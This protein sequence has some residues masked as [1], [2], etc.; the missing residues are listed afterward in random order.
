MA[1]TIDTAFLI[2]LGKGSR[3]V[4]ADSLSVHFKG[5]SL[6][7]PTPGCNCELYHVPKKQQLGRYSIG[8]HFAR[9][10]GQEHNRSV[11]NFPNVEDRNDEGS[12]ADS[13]WASFFDTNGRPPVGA[14]IIYLNSGNEREDFQ[15]RRVFRRETNRFADGGYRTYK[16]TS[17]DRTL[18]IGNAADLRRMGTH[19]D[20]ANPFYN[21]VMIS[22][23]GYKVPFR[24]FFNRNY[25]NLYEIAKDRGERSIH[26]PIATEVEPFTH[27]LTGGRGK[28]PFKVPCKTQE[29]VLNGD[30]QVRFIPVLLSY[31]PDVLQSLEDN[32]RR[33]VWP[34]ETWV[35]LDEVHRRFSLVDK[36]RAH[37]AVI[38]IYLKVDDPDQFA[39]T[40]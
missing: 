30:T 29:A 28:T 22:A 25:Q 14:R 5:A 7:C 4:R 15:L 17:Y 24:Q 13:R 11:C 3:P 35:D 16:S 10:P 36:G 33:V 34:R 6:V 27:R 20:Y 37:E 31:T 2:E 26:Q 18:S 39:P 8:A 21:N 40:R 19:I 23:N 12:K 9:K 1:V 32:K 38:P